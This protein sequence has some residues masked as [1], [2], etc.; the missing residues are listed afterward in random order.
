M[1][2]SKKQMHEAERVLR[3]VFENDTVWAAGEYDA[4]GKAYIRHNGTVTAYA[5]NTEAYDA[6]AEL[7][8]EAE[9]F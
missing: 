1:R 9:Q 8:F 7:V 2:T 4:T 6:I 3:S 5:S